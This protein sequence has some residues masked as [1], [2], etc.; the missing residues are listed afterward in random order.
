MAKLLKT[1][2][3]NSILRLGGVHKGYKHERMKYTD[4]ELEKLFYKEWKEENKNRPHI[5]YGYGALQDLFCYYDKSTPVLNRTRFHIVTNKRDQYIAATIIQWL[6]TNCGFA[7]LKSV[8]AKAGYD[9]VK[10]KQ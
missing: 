9:I 1:V 3:P 2:T 4:N 5:N 8:L 10:R 7:F 6:G